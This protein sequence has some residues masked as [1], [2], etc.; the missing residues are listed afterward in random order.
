[1]NRAA[2]TDGR[3][4]LR[5]YVW[6]EGIDNLLAVKIG[7]ESY[8]PLAD[9][10]GTVWGYADSANNVVARWTYDAWG[11][12]L[13][14][15]VSVPALASL[16]YRFQGREWSAATGLINFRMRWYDAETGRWLSKD[17]IGL[18]GGLNLYAFCENEPLDYRDP[19]G[20][21]QIGLRGLGGS[22]TILALGI[23]GALIPI[24]GPMVHSN[25]GLFH[26]HIYFEDGDQEC[27]DLGYFEDG[28]HPDPIKGAK[29]H[30][31]GRH[32]DD[33]TMRRA[34]NNL[35]ASGKWGARTQKD[36]GYNFLHHNCQDFI[37]A[38]IVEYFR[39]GGR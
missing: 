2:K 26:E 30:K 9:I 20:F 32:Y 5:S 18:G 24:T 31:Y 7:N 3:G 11:N 29:P 34:V 13:S 4:V 37:D 33:D 36:G 16:R 17:P 10:Q 22:S 19:N 35:R 38:V 15:D 39:I 8:C 1:M 6:G 27:P 23:T 28:I 14:E 21:A 25:L 12:V